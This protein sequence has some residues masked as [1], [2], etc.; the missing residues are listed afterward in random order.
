MAD[1]TKP[2]F[3]LPDLP[4]AP[5]SDLGRLACR[6]LEHRDLGALTRLPDMLMDMGR[7]K[8]AEILREE[9]AEA[10]WQM[11][12]G[13]VGGYEG[14]WG[15]FAPDLARLLWWSI[16]SWEATLAVMA[17][18]L[19]P[20]EKITF[21]GQL[22]PAVWAGTH[23]G[24]PVTVTYGTPRPFSIESMNVAEAHA[25]EMHPDYE[26][27]QLRHPGPPDQREWEVNEELNSTAAFFCWRRRLLQ[28]TNYRT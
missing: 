12:A 1:T 8:D 27:R 28:P 10:I 24:A 26:Y 11:H 14:A 6:I 18:E 19:A 7:E 3:P 21:T 13:E 20:K 5:E 4:R 9:I 2:P 25:R 22:N 16:F 17:K 23:T 15:R